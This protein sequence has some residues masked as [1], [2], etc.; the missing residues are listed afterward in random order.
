MQ[1]FIGGQ[2]QRNDRFAIFDAIGDGLCLSG[3]STPD[4]G[5]LAGHAE[6]RFDIF[7]AVLLVDE[8]RSCRHPASLRCTK[9]M[10][11]SADAPE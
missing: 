2:G 3:F 6:A 7:G 11:L 1:Q 4:F 8:E 5:G 10:E 9:G